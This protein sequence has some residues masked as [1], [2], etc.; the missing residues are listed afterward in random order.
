[1]RCSAWL[2]VAFAALVACPFPARGQ[3]IIRTGSG[4]SRNNDWRRK[5]LEKAR[6]Q[7]E[8]RK[9]TQEQIRKFEERRRK[10][11]EEERK[12]AQEASSEAIKK[13]FDKGKEAYEE[14]RY[15][16]AYLH[17]S[18]VARCGLKDVAKMAAEARAKIAEIDGMAIAKLNQAEILLLKG[19]AAEAAKIFLEIVQDFPH[20]EPAKRARS[21]LRAVKSTPAVAASLRYSEGKSHD[22]AENYGEALNIYDE[23]VLRWPEEIAALR[24]KVAAKKI[25]QDPE[26]SEMAAE[27]LEL[28]AERRCPT[29]INI[30]M[31]FLINDDRDTARGK[32]DQIIQDYPGTTYAEQAIVALAA[33][34]EER[35]KAALKILGLESDEEEEPK[36]EAPSAE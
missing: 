33:I 32:L 29:I 5:Q 31:N 22:D 35:P 3:T 16:V 30:A 34:A 1:M 4:R 12:K 15:S 14:E 13:A 11:K 2:L 7:A 25:R 17:F 6:K 8:Q 19:S 9:K 20:G 36:P 27:A 21:R 10:I 28:E 18:S 24:A 26:K 23:V